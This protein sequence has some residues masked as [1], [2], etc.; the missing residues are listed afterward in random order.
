MTQGNHFHFKLHLIL[1]KKCEEYMKLSQLLHT[2]S[3]Q[4]KILVF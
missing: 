4:E 1:D 3:F 2:L